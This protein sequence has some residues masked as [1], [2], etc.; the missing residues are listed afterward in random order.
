MG[1]H[2]T[3]LSDTYPMTTNRTGFTWFSK[4]FTLFF[5]GWNFLQCFISS[6]NRK[7]LVSD[8]A[9]EMLYNSLR[10]FIY[11][12]R[13]GKIYFQTRRKGELWMLVRQTCGRCPINHAAYEY[14]MWHDVLYLYEAGRE[15]CAAWTKK[16]GIIDEVLTPVGYITP[17]YIAPNTAWQ[18]WRYLPNKSNFHK[19]FQGEILTRN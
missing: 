12:D 2:L 14:D 7:D 5:F 8:K 3:V 4:I 15:F 16:A 1:T 6:D 10:W 13:T 19:I 9:G 17:K 11:S 18:L